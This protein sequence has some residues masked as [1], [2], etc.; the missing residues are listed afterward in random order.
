MIFL[1]ISYDIEVLSQNSIYN[2]STNVQCNSRNLKIY[3]SVPQNG[4][5][6]NTGLL[7]FI[8]GFGGQ[9]TSNVYKKMRDNFSDKY[10]L[11]TIQ[12]DYFGYEF[13]QKPD[14]VHFPD[15]EKFNKIFSVEE[16]EEIYKGG[17]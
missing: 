13:M 14:N 15:R 6:E 16:M 12:C 3:F 4:V 11:V 2:K 9:A 8:A 7:L 1:A 17:V 5:D 10:N